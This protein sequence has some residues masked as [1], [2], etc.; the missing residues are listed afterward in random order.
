VCVCCLYVFAFWTD[1]FGL[2]NQ[3]G[4]SLLER[5]VFYPASANQNGE[6]WSPFPADNI[7]NTIP[8]PKPEIIV[9]EVKT[10]GLK[11][12]RVEFSGRLSPRN[13][14]SYTRKTLETFIFENWPDN[15]KAWRKASFPSSLAS[16]WQ[17]PQTI[18]PWDSHVCASSLLYSLVQLPNPPRPLL[19]LD[20]PEIPPYP[21]SSNWLLPS[22]LT[23]SRDNLEPLSTDAWCIF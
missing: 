22:L 10:V 1:I 12:N 21:L 20:G 9:E 16:T 17:R 3:L 11:R 15:S 13:I 7:C 4:C 19:F 23:Q 8:A 5:R 6:L 14:R 18:G 2:D